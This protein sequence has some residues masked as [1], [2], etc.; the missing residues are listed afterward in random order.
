MSLGVS[1]PAVRASAMR[2]HHM[3][4]RVTCTH[5]YAH[6]HTCAGMCA[7]VCHTWECALHALGNAK[8]WVPVRVCP[9]CVCP[10]VPP[11][12]LAS[13]HVPTAS[14]EEMLKD[15]V[16]S[17]GLTGAISKVQRRQERRAPSITGG[18]GPALC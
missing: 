18:D 1:V 11:S 13:T 16:V 6:I 14:A 15:G 12:V 2:V 4:V 7:H 8:L 17:P 5:R 9:A 10:A 3:G